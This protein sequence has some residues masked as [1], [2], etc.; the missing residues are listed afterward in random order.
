M[1]DT[2]ATIQVDVWSDIA[3]PWCYV[4][5]ARLEQAVSE[6]E[7]GAA[8]DIRHRSFELDPNFPSDEI[9]PVIPL[10]AKKYGATEEQIE[11]NEDRLGAMAAELGLEYRTRGRDHG[12][13][14]DLH[15]L[16]HLARDMGKE[17]EVWQAFY[18][19]NFADEES[20]YQ[21]DR[22]I[23]VAVA[24]GLE[25]H[26][27]VAVLDDPSAYADAVRAE[28]KQAAALGAT[29]VPF[30][31]IDNRFGISGAQPVE[32]F[33]EA[34]DK[35]WAEKPKLETFAAGEACGPDGC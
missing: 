3:C 9:S 1:T 24:A 29:G 5:K 31:V 35:A 12:N 16:L 14:F 32:L 21:R 10:I 15:R 2:N 20:I 11:Q 27:V 22:M 7:H 25:R 18:R 28:E 4:G 17:A 8:V 13:T 26:D 34:L 6:F 19:G 23:D 30:F 33:G